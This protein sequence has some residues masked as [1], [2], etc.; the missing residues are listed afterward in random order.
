MDAARPGASARPQEITTPIV[1]AHTDRSGCLRWTD[2][3]VLIVMLAWRCGYAYAVTRPPTVA[4]VEAIDDARRAPLLPPARPYAARVADRTALF[5]AC[6]DRTAR[7]LGRPAGWTYRGGPVDWASG[8]PVTR[9][10]S[11]YG[12]QAPPPSPEMSVGRG[13]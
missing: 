10:V 3:G 6:A 1:A 13:G 9:N 8:E 4:E 5:E 7:T 12:G 2:D 11:R